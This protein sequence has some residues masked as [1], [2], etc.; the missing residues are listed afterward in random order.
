VGVVDGITEG[1]MVGE[2]EVLGPETGLDDGTTVEAGTL[3]P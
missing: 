2:E 1:V 3:F